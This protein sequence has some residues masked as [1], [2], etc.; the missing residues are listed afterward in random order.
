MARDSRLEPTTADPDRAAATGAGREGI[1]AVIT[2]LGATTPLGGDVAG[3]WEAMLRGESGIGLLDEESSAHLLPPLPVGRA[4]VEPGPE[5]EPMLRRRLSRCAQLAVT[6]AQEAWMDAGLDALSISPDRIGVVVS[7]AM[8]DMTSIINAWE[9]L[10]DKGWNRV[11]PMSV[12]WCLASS[13][14]SAVS[15]LVNAQAGIHATVNACSSGTQ[16]LATAL[17]VIRRG[18]ADV[19]VAGGAEAPVHPA[20]LGSLAAMRAL[21]RRADD[22]PAASRPFDAERDG[23]VLSEGSGVVILESETHAL[24]RGARIYAEL[25]GAGITSDA[26]HLVQPRPDGTGTVRAIRASLND[27]GVAPAEVAHVNANGTS[28]VPGDAAEGR[29]F[30]AVFGNVGQGPIL[31]ANKSLLGHSLGA[32]GAIESIATILSVYHGVVPPTRNFTCPDEN[33]SL[34]V[35]HGE[36]RQLGGGQVVAMKNSAGFGGHNVALIFRGFPAGLPA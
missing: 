36:P 6:A 4:R 18:L 21:S 31:T 10:R 7:A 20:V 16:A 17:D 15:M 8:G 19:V 9:A 26:H 35:V 30:Q 5:L 34:D 12:P 29:A 1:H 2:G 33:L 25:A 3:T 13:S 11:P 32:A 23:L 14:A 22:P 27:A 28:T 24:R